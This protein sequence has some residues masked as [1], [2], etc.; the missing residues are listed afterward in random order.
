MTHTH[1]PRGG[2]E[3]RVALPCWPV[4]GVTRGFTLVELLVVVAIIGIASAGVTFALRDGEQ[5]SL[6]REAERLAALLESGRAHSRAQG[7]TVTWRVTESGAFSFD[8]LPT[9]T[10]PERWL[11][12]DVQPRAAYRIALGPEPLIGP[13]IV[14]LTS[15][16]RPEREVAVATDGLRPFRVGAQAQEQAVAAGALAQAGAAR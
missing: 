8:G 3:P 14:R 15:R 7:S 11:S 4:R 1:E 6:E 9:G 10:L 13:Q 2:E 12:D 16:T 5:A